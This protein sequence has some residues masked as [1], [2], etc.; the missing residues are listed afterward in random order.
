M[1]TEFERKLKEL[2]FS[3]QCNTDGLYIM[4]LNN[5]PD[6]I[7]NAQLALSEPGDEVIHGSR[8]NNKTQAI[9]LFKLRLPAEIKEQDF[10]ILVF[11]NTFNH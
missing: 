4:R 6:R 8:N 5:D 10:L 3:Y 7:I 1:K 2:G 9:G 11:Q